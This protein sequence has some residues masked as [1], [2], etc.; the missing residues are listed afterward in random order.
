MGRRSA[1]HSAPVS[2]R[3]SGIAGALRCGIAAH[4]GSVAHVRSGLGLS[5]SIRRRISANKARGTALVETPTTFQIGQGNPT[6]PHFSWTA[7]VAISGNAGDTFA[8]FNA[9]PHP[10]V[11]CL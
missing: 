5:R 11:R 1:P 8:N 3:V 4:V 6:G 2:W 7:D 10:V 9:G